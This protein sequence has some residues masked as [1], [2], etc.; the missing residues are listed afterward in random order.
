MIFLLSFSRTDTKRRIGW[1]H[2]AGTLLPTTWWILPVLR[3][4]KIREVEEVVA[5][6]L[7]PQLLLLG[8]QS[9]AVLARLSE[10]LIRTSSRMTLVTRR[11]R[12][13]R[14]VVS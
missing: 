10:Q 14:L 12:E 5:G 8:S 7:F 6:L 9:R 1:N 13:Q 11:E 4:V 3:I 2:D